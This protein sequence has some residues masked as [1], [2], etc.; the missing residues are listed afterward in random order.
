MTLEQIIQWLRLDVKT[1]KQ[2]SSEITGSYSGDFI[3][4]VMANAHQDNVCVTWHIHPDI[5]PLG[6]VLATMATFMCGHPD[7][8]FNYEH[9][10]DGTS[11]CRWDS[12]EPTKQARTQKW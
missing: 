8:K 1:A 11:V 4:A 5:K 6:D 2:C 3:S 12:S 7:S 9:R 10:R